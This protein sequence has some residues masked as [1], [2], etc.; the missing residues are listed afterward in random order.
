[1][2]IRNVGQNTSSSSLAAR[3]TVII[4]SPVVKMSHQPFHFMKTKKVRGGDDEDDSRE[5]ARLRLQS[6]DP[7]PYTEEDRS[8]Q[9]NERRDSFAPVNRFGD[10]KRH[11]SDDESSARAFGFPPE[12]SKHRFRG[13][14]GHSGGWTGS[15]NDTS[16]ESMMMQGREIQRAAAARLSTKELGKKKPALEGKT[17]QGKTPQDLPVTVLIALNPSGLRDIFSQVDWESLGYNSHYG[18]PSVLS[19]EEKQTMKHPLLYLQS[20]KRPLRAGSIP[21]S[22]SVE[23]AL[24]E[25][26][27]EH[28]IKFTVPGEV[29]GR[30]N[31]TASEDVARHLFA[32]AMS[33]TGEKKDSINI[34]AMWSL[35]SRIFLEGGKSGGVTIPVD[36]SFTA[37][38][39]GWRKRSGPNPLDGDEAYLG[40]RDMKRCFVNVLEPF[41]RRTKGMQT[42]TLIVALKPTQALVERHIDVKRKDGDDYEG[43]QG[44]SDSDDSEGMPSR[45]AGVT[46]ASALDIDDDGS[47]SADS[48]KDVGDKKYSRMR[49]IATGNAPSSTMASDSGMASSSGMSSGQSMASGPSMA[50]GSGV[51][52]GSGMASGNAPDPMKARL[53]IGNAPIGREEPFSAVESE[54]YAV[55]ESRLSDLNSRFGDLQRKAQILID[56]DF[57][58][59]LDEID[60][61]LNERLERMESRL[62]AMEML[63]E[64]ESSECDAGSGISSAA[65]KQRVQ[66]EPSGRDTRKGAGTQL[67]FFIVAAL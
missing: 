12:P 7:F 59:F 33:E 46:A 61:K 45:A 56:L 53:R 58:V 37:N 47:S 43:S 27:E 52:S 32:C 8:P 50:S 36:L 39:R 42:R 30:F 49:G 55:L 13:S 20:I 19:A 54:R 10:S 3:Y 66:R 6:R 5:R 57:T 24:N 16:D 23:N 38:P 11:D 28:G 29:T 51:A 40:P 4:K 67:L 25:L 41:A 63:K 35:A 65:S 62:D 64:V 31:R 22:L 14:I 15:W 34:T 44:N 9:R 60:R 2:D 26:F 18:S 48:R 17:P 1:M 21:D